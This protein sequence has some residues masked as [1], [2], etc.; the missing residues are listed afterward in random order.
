MKRPTGA[1]RKWRAGY[2]AAAAV[3]AVGMAGTTLP[4]PLYGL[5]RDQ[6]G[7]SELMVTVVFAVYALGVIATLLLA[8]NV[9]DET[10]AADPYSWPPSASRRPARSAS[11]SRVGFPPSSPAG[12][13]PGSP[14]AC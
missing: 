5:Y 8:G 10:R 1:T 7:F 13:S 9:S 12:S 2:P 11:S 3:F 6:L 14:P 4:T